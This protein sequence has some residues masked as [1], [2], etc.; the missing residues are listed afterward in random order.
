MKKF[1]L[2]VGVVFLTVLFSISAFS[3]MQGAKIALINSESFFDEKVG[4]TKLV[5]ANQKLEA[6]FAVRVKELK[7]GTARLVE[8]LTV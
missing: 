7:D 2:L 5:A 8:G 4:I 3:Q 6:E 1:S